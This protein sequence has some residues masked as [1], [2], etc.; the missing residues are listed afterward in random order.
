MNTF[1]GSNAG[2]DYADRKTAQAKEYLR[3]QFKDSDAYREVEKYNQDG[4]ITSNFPIHIWNSSNKM[5][6]YKN[7]ISHPDNPVNYG[8]VFDLGDDKVIVIE[9]N[10]NN[11]ISD[12]G[13]VYNCNETLKFKNDGTVYTQPCYVDYNTASSTEESEFD[14]FQ[15]QKIKVYVQ[16]TDNLKLIGLNQD[17]IFGNN[18]KNKYKTIGINDSDK[19]GLVQVYMEIVQF[20]VGDNTNDNVADNPESDSDIKVI[21]SSIDDS[22]Y[23]ISPNDGNIIKYEN[24][25]YV[26]EHYDNTGTII[27]SNFTYDVTGVSTTAYDLV[28]NDNNNISIT[29]NED[30]GIANLEIINNDYVETIVFEINLKGLF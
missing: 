4:T 18:F 12:D 8:D 7:F 1:N 9:K 20:D 13:M 17:F 26:I 2:T 5:N 14:S 23:T 22:Y 29:C 19:D 10:E 24:V 15:S 25:N 11:R 27:N 30:V 3:V 21:N 16:Y 6:N 28:V